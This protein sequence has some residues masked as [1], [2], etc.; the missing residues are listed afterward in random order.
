[1]IRKITA[2]LVDDERQSRLVLKNILRNFSE[3]ITIVGEANSIDS[4]YEII[5]QLKPELVFLDIQMPRG[6]GFDLLMKFPEIFFEV[7]FVTSYDRYAINA[8]KFSALDYLLK[9]IEIQELL[10]TINRAF[11]RIQQKQNAIP[12]VVNLLHTLNSDQNE[13]RIAV[14][15]A[16]KVKLIETS[17]I[18]H[19]EA[20]GS[21][22]TIFTKDNEKLVTSKYLKDFEEYFGEES[23]FVRIHKSYLINILEMVSYSKGEPCFIM[24]TNQKTFEVARRK[25]QEV[26]QRLKTITE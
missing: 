25:K 22:C 13:H 21:Y 16:D 12:L 15:S 10:N 7:I 18:V 9:P 26:L 24:M 4:A 23:N 17:N 8:I 5:Q 14:Q 11:V 1:M 3:K 2:V 19:I 6:S 20:S